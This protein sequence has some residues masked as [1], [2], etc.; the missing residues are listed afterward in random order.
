MFYTRTI[1]YRDLYRLKLFITTSGLISPCYIYH[2]YEASTL[3]IIKG[4]DLE[5]K[6]KGNVRMH[7]T[8]EGQTY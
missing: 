2:I 5:V 3:T 8:F 6:D 4:H 7:S 1:N